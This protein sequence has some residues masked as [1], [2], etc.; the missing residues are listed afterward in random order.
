P[1]R[2]AVGFVEEPDG[3]LLVAAGSATSHWVANIVA[4][5]VCHGTIGEVR[6]AYRAEEVAGPDR[7]RAIRELILKYGTPAER[8]GAGPAFRLRP[9]GD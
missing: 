5:P 6:R 9:V 3:S 7:T 1:R 8:L 2:T 4:D